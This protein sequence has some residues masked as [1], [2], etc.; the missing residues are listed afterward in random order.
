MGGLQANAQGKY[1]SN[2]AKRNA[3]LE[4]EAA[5]ESVL[6]GQD[7]R[8][9][10]WRKIGQ[11]KGQNLAAMAANG[12]DVGYGSA[13]RLQD[14]TAILASEDAKNLYGNIE[15]RTRGH[16]INAS[17]FVAE[18]KAARQRGKA[19]LTQSFFGAAS[20]L[21]GGATQYASLKAKMPGG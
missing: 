6:A 12:I 4:V 2:I 1:E 18:A 7:E 8:R 9:A 5:R 17:N 10:F 13:Q 19:A 3:A 16:H 21:L 20:S 14:D 11:V 15:K